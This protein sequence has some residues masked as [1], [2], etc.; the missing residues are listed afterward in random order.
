M[1]KNGEKTIEQSTN[2]NIE[3]TTATKN[4]MRFKVLRKG[5]QVLL[6]LCYSCTYKYCDKTQTGMSY[7]MIVWDCG[8]DNLNICIVFWNKYSDTCNQLVMVPVNSFE[9]IIN[10]KL[11]E[12]YG[13]IAFMQAATHYQ[14][15]HDF[16]HTLWNIFSTRIYITHMQT[17]L[18]CCQ[19]KMESLQLRS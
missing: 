14:E 3:N 8:K 6:P 11:P 19:I 10:T 18:E 9:G 2:H 4:E 5:N 1:D 17:L 13:L 16:A 12:T 7:F 15:N